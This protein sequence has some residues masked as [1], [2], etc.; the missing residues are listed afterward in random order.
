MRARRHAVEAAAVVVGGAVLGVVVSV[1]LHAARIGVSVWYCA[2]AAVSVLAVLRLART[3]LV[4]AESP[5]RPAHG[6]THGR[7]RPVEVLAPSERRLSAAVRERRLYLAGLQPRLLDL[8]RERLRLR[9]GIDLDRAVRDGTARD[10]LGDELWHWLTIWDEDG[11]AP[12]PA[13]LERLVTRLETLGTDR[14]GLSRP[15]RA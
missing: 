14:P 10:L 15:G 5:T 2:A 1:V 4:Q 3:V 8:A 9:A 11:P 7:P 13:E 12:T 6:A